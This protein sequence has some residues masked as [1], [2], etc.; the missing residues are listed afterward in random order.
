MAALHLEEDDETIVSELPMLGFVRDS[1]MEI[2]RESD[3]GYV[4]HP[5]TDRPAKFVREI[6]EAR[7]LVKAEPS[8]SR[9]KTSA[10]LHFEKPNHQQ[11]VPL[12]EKSIALYSK[13]IDRWTC[14]MKTLSSHP[15][16]DTRPWNIPE[17]EFENWAG[18][19]FSCNPMLRFQMAVMHLLDFK[20][21][22]ML[23]GN[24]NTEKGTKIAYD[25]F[26]Q[27]SAGVWDVKINCQ[28]RR[29]SDYYSETSPKYTD[30]KPVVIMTARHVIRIYE[31]ALL[32]MVI[33]GKIDP[34]T[35]YILPFV[36]RRC[37][38]LR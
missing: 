36:S 25:F 28:W 30:K 7:D 38:K 33:S 17:T 13:A 12:I 29:F 8:D 26:K 18:V 4:D 1:H 14:A 34:D 24:G 27:Y 11:R 3:Y 9:W 10:G 37:P 22:V 15:S 31:G 32:E 16:Y 35:E 5:I 2:E 19:M 20:E 21:L 6:I 23:L